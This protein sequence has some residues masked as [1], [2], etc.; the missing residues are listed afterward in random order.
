MIKT[1][2]T[3]LQDVILPFNWDV[4]KVWALPAAVQAHP[5]TQFSHLFDLPLWS[6][7]PNAG[8]LFDLTPNAVLASPHR[9]PHQQERLA[10]ADTRY[11][12]DVILH[13]DRYFILDGL[14]RLARLAQQ[15]CATVSVRC[16]PLS[17]RVQIEVE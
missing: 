3:P 13:N 1:V 17:I 14:H 10:Q 2:P 5:L 16:H 4:R 12:I 9:Y 6:S 7:R 15:Q 8:M 11:P